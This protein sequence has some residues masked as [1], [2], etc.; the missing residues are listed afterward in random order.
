[1]IPGEI[2]VRDEPV[3]LNVGRDRQ[4][5]VVVNDGDRPIQVGSHAQFCDVNPA[6]GFDR[7]AARGY[8]LAVP[9]G[10]SVRFEP[11]VSRSVELVALAGRRHVPGIRIRRARGPEMTYERQ[12]RPVV[13]FG[14][15]GAPVEEP[16]RKPRT[17]HISNEAPSSGPDDT[18]PGS[19]GRSTSSS[20]GSGAGSEGSP[21]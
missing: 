12:P 7:D 10:T 20:T 5:I 13:P 2:R 4:T 1:V 14:T 15:P 16:S 21:S 11:G 18:G 17:V 9:A 3:E 8:R 6:L 19:T